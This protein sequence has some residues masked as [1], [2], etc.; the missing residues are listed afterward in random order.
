MARLYDLSL[1]LHAQCR[2]AIH[3]DFVSA[4]FLRFPHERDVAAGLTKDFCRSVRAD[5]FCL[6]A[7]GGWPLLLFFTAG[8]RFRPLGWMYVISL[9]LFLVAKG[10][11]YYLAPAYPML[12]AAGPLSLPTPSG[13]RSR[14]LRRCA[15]LSGPR[16]CISIVGSVAVALPVAPVGS[17]VVLQIRRY[18]H[19]LSDEIGWEDL[20]SSIAAVRDTLPPGER[21]RVVVLAENYGE[22]GAINIL[23]PRY[24]LP[25]PS[26]ESIP[27]GNEGMAIRRR[28]R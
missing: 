7:L 19:A 11:G 14:P 24:G 20:L 22:V 3:H 15:R 6:S 25:Q 18:R 17:L 5:P 23:G 27:P 13:W 9:L 1:H 8:G 10:R 26:V 21:A 2:L 28:R 16:S 12:Y 4:D